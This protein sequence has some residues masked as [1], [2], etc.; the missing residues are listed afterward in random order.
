M[1]CLHEEQL[2]VLAKVANRF[3]EEVALGRMVGIEDHNQVALGH[4]QAGVQV[5]RLRMHV[6]LT[7]E[8]VDAKLRAER[9]EFDGAAMRGGGQ[10]AVARVQFLL[11]RAIVE[12]RHR[13]LAGWVVHRLGRRERERQDIGRLVEAGNQDIDA[14]RR[15]RLGARRGRPLLGVGH[16]EQADAEHDDGVHL[17]EVQQQTRNERG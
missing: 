4:R 15:R 10:H 7:G 3:G 11:R 17:G 8:V 14:W 2:G 12:Q 1:R 16:D 9:L 13:Q 6:A 5:A